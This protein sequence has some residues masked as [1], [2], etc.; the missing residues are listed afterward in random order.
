MKISLLILILSLCLN[1]NDLTIEKKIYEVI[2]DAV[3]YKANPAVYTDVPIASLELTTDKFTRT[4]VCKEADIVI[5]TKNTIDARCL[6][7]IILG[8][9]Y[10]HLKKPYVLGAFFWQKGRPNIVFKR[11]NLIKKRVNLPK[12]LQE[13]V[14]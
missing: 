1:A 14:E 4:N 8:T 6:K 9:R 3:S 13:F 11:R 10:R 2:F 12:S 5:V 7:K